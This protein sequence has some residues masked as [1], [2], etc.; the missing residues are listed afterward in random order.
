MKK[1]KKFT[2]VFLVIIMLFLN[3]SSVFA[4]S[5][6]EPVSMNGGNYKIEF[7]DENSLK[8]L[9]NDGKTTIM[10]KKEDD[11]SIYIYADGVLYSKV[12]KNNIA[13][14]TSSGEFNINLYSSSGY[15]LYINESMSYRAWKDEEAK[16]IGFFSLLMGGVPGFIYN[17]VSYVKQLVEPIDDTIYVNYRRYIDVKGDR[18]KDVIRFK[19]GGPSGKTLKEEVRVWN[20]IPD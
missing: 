4:Y 20:H 15:E 2:V 1:L 10:S 9:Y 12:D 13:S 3:A 17:C 14:T 18:Q 5:D 7:I 8:I 11:N 19:K 16:V 6:T